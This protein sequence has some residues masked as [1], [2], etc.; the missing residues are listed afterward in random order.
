MGRTGRVGV[1]V[2]GGF[3]GGWR[4]RRCDDAVDACRQ[5]GSQ[6]TLAMPSAAGVSQTRLRKAIY[7]A[8]RT[9]QA[10]HGLA[11]PK[12]MIDVRLC[13][14]LP[15]FCFWRVEL[16]CGGWLMPLEAQQHGHG[17]KWLASLLQ[18]LWWMVAAEYN[19][20]GSAPMCSHTAHGL[21]RSPQ[22]GCSVGVSTRWLAAEWPQAN[23]RRS[24]AGVAGA[25][26]L[27]AWC[28]ICAA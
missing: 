12:D 14:S 25:V 10:K 17:R 16:M 11:E 18:M 23:V 7:T 9:F 2:G 6:L 4:R 15:A 1:E 21:F 24:R 19:P 22:I 28:L 26:P 8:I 20:E 13:W 5:G 3:G 27:P